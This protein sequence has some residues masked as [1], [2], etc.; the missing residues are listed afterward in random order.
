MENCKLT[1]F[2]DGFGHDRQ[3]AMG[4]ILIDSK[5]ALEFHDDGW[6]GDVDITFTAKGKE[7]LSKFISDSNIC[8]HIF[9]DSQKQEYKLFK[10]VEE[11]E[12]DYVISIMFDYLANQLSEQ[13]QIKKIIREKDKKIIGGTINRYRQT[14]WTKRTL[15]EVSALKGGDVALQKA[16]DELKSELKDGEQI[17]N[18]EHLASIGIKV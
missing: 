18:L 7:M 8:Q 5:K 9:D 17:F 4:N 1:A 16:Y 2:K 13:K 6:G 12:E 14:S 3:G 15:T 10:K 11:V